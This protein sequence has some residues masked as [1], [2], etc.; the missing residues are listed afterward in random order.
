M[1]Q[2]DD[3]EPLGFTTG[4]RIPRPPS[5]RRVG[6][7][8]LAAHL[9]ELDEDLFAD[10]DPRRRSAA[11]EQATVRLLMA[12]I[13]RCDLEPWLHAAGSGPGLLIV[14]GLLASETCL[15][16]RTVTS[17]LGASDLLQP[18]EPN[19]D[20][21]LGERSTWRA[22]IPTQLVLLDAAF[23][24]RVQ[25]W[26]QI[27][28]ALYRRAGRRAT[29]TDALRAISCQPKLE[30]RLV[31]L[32][33]H[34]ASRWGRVQTGGLRLSLP[35]T[36]RLLGQL[37]AAERPSISHALARLSNAGIVTGTA[38][39]WTLHGD[40]DAHLSGLIERTVPDPVRRFDRRS[41]VAGSRASSERSDMASGNPV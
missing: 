11:R 33:W 6:S 32:L 9:L 15:A 36:H 35:L 13:G 40:L 12:D 39:D 19:L 3:P 31:L 7:V 16:G 22:L 4:Q 27:T 41:S 14:E 25:A 34:L 23:L 8:R 38:G 17:L 18:A 26:P 10:I 29:A 1:L 5:G 20:D 24:D 37:V 2:P 21:M 30:V 28:N